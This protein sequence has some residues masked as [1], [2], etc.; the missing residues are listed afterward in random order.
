MN[1]IT[2]IPV[3]KEVSITSMY[4]RNGRRSLRSYPKRMELEGQ[5]YTFIESGLH[6]VV[7][8]GQQLFEL[9]DMTDGT[10]EYRLK[11][12]ATENTWTL[13]GMNEAP[14]AFA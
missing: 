9:F 1:N 7:K 10:N 13:V 4:F 2:R 12:D 6:F 3:N 14:R 11:H 5:E 8:K